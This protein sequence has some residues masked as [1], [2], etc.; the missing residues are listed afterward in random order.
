MVVASFCAVRS[1]PFTAS[2]R[3]IYY[4]ARPPPQ[5]IGGVECWNTGVLL[6]C[7][8][9]LP[10]ATSFLPQYSTVP[11]FH[12]SSSLSPRG[13]SLSRRISRLR[14]R[15]MLAPSQGC[16]RLR[17]C[18]NPNLDKSPVFFLFRETLWFVCLT[19]ASSP[20]PYKTAPVN[21]RR[22]R[23]SDS[24]CRSGGVILS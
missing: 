23:L 15:L 14:S 17:N 1:K 4:P 24:V 12:H 3:T 18:P 2:F 16:A 6:N 5:E 10:T 20:S 9:R 22:C 8:L 19:L 13:C 7:R 21:S 11:I